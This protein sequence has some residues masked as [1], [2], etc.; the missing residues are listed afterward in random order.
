MSARDKVTAI[1]RELAGE[2]A[3]R[4][5]ATH[6]LADVNSRITAALSSGKKEE[7]E[8]LRIDQIG[9]HLVDWQAEAAFIVALSLYPERFT[10]EEIQEG[11]EAFLLHAP[12]HVVEAARLA[13]MASDTVS[14]KEKAE[15]NQTSEPT[16]ASD[17]GS[18]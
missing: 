6:F 11:V 10:D 3:A 8:I 5:E 13:A 2:K 15:S 17:R 7:A 1:F 4:L 14:S 18:P 9:F 16:A 12:S